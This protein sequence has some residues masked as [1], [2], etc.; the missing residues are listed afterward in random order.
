MVVRELRGIQAWWGE[1]DLCVGILLVIGLVR[2]KGRVA[3]RGNRFGKSC[4]SVMGIVGAW[5]YVVVQLRV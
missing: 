4:V 2:G 1:L 5:V 3:H